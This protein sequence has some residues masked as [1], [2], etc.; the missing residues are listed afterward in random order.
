MTLEE[1]LK[2]IV[3]DTVRTWPKKV[4]ARELLKQLDTFKNRVKA[5]CLEE[6]S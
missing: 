5:A 1:R 6:Q 2:R 4:D 3:V